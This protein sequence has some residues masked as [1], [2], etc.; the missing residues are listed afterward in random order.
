M[1]FGFNMEI[2]SCIK[3]QRES[4]RPLGMEVGMKVYL[5]RGYGLCGQSVVL[6]FMAR[7]PPL[8]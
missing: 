5:A 8:S 7:S 1:L 6:T 3:Y 2:H 4:V